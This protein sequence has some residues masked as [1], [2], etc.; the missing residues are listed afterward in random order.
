MIIK[1]NELKIGDVF[2]FHHKH[3]EKDVPCE[4]V[5]TPI[6][7]KAEPPFEPLKIAIIDYWVDEK[8]HEQL[9]LPD[10]ELWDVIYRRNEDYVTVEGTMIK[11]EKERNED[12]TEE[13]K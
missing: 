8:R 4:V 5:D 9:M 10:D 1:T 3:Y 12:K 13:I 2:F 7:Y 11:A 6:L